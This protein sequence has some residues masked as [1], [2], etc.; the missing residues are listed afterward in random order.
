[1]LLGGKFYVKILS[2]GEENK[3]KGEGPLRDL[4]KGP[5]TDSKMLKMSKND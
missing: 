3:R 4:S 5:L 1:M 2:S